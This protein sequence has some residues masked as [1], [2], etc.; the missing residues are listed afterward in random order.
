MMPIH[1]RRAMA[2]RVLRACLVLPWLTAPAAAASAAYPA[3]AARS[4]GD[5]L[6][7]HVTDTGG[8]DIVGATVTLEEIARQV[9]TGAGGTFT[10]GDVPHGRYTIAVRRPGYAPW[11]RRIDFTG[12]MQLDA[13]LAASP[14]RLAGVVVTAS[15]SPLTAFESPLPLS[16]PTPEAL[17]REHSMSLAHRIDGLPGVHSLTTGG[18]TGKPVIRGVA[19]SRV[20]VLQDGLRLEDY[21]WSDEDGPSVDAALAGRVE[22][23]RGPASLLYGS[24]AIGGVVNVVP[25]TLPESPPGTGRRRGSVEVYGASNAR[26]MGVQLTEEGARGGL[27]W[28]LSGVG[29]FGGDVHTPRA[30]LENTGYGAVNGQGELGWH[31][32]WGTATVR[33]DRYGGEF[34]LLEA[35]GP[36]PGLE[37]KDKGPER[38]LGDDRVQVVANLARGLV[39]IEPRVQLQR[40]WL[41]ELADA[42]EVG[43]AGVTETTIFDL[44]LT[45]LTGDILVHADAGDRVRTTLGVSGGLQVNDSRAAAP[46]LPFVPDASVATAAAFGV[47]QVQAGR[48]SLLGGLR[49]DHRALSSDANPVLQLNAKDVDQTAVSGSAGAA[50]RL[51]G[52]A[53]ATVN[54]GRAWRAPNLFEL[55]ANGPLLA[56]GRYVIGNDALEPEESTN[57]DAGLRWESARVRAEMSA[58]RNRVAH[59]I[60][61][62]PTAA[63]RRTPG[64]PGD[65][66][67]VFRYAAGEARLTGA[68][69]GVEVSPADHVALRGRYDFVHG[70]NEATGEDLPLMPPPRLDLEAELR[71][72]DLHG[73]GRSFVLVGVELDDEQR[74]LHPLDTPTHG[75]TLLNLGAGIEPVLGHRRYRVSL[76]V[77]NAGNTAYRS[78]LSRYKSFALN[79]GRDLVLRVSTDTHGEAGD[80]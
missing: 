67:P 31:G 77:H 7:G 23:I 19:G 55:F 33:Y 6:R 54:L 13:T 14:F 17:G 52:G 18:Q 44:L 5:S 51:G 73:L 69:M 11:V 21:S 53:V 75:Y 37:G 39:R 10:M 65:S 25:A 2:H 70:R 41:A 28:R 79:P 35:N 24:D 30:A 43:G 71:T 12:G 49:V 56:E 26:E 74:H 8:R 40:H 58:Y 46:G 32:D 80:H 68:E 45:T 38:K 16:S 76:R 47:G 61:L 20:L 62:T 1:R 72:P 64:S 4:T 78:F 60:A 63:Y 57:L 29:R 9:V 66:L 15:R 48:V 22:V 34:R 42:A 27:G 3:P 50:V 59:H 36:P